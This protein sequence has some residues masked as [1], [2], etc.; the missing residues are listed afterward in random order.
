MPIDQLYFYILLA[1]FAGGAVRGLS[2]WV[3]SWPG[4][5]S[6]F[7]WIY[8]SVT[9][10]VSGLVGLAAAYAANGSGIP[11]FGTMVNPPIALII[12]YAGGDFIE[13]VFRIIFKKP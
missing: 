10:G 13:N 1:G 2:G 12:G 4:K 9:V 8:F 3:R 7:D 6:G 5:G 11:F